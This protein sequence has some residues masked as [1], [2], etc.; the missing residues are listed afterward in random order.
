MGPLNQ[1]PG[2]KTR[3]EARNVGRNTAG[4]ANSEAN[5]LAS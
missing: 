4:A 1:Q 3:G 5:L 2:G